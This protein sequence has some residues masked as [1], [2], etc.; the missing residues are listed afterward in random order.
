MAQIP[1]A[2]PVL[3][4]HPVDD[5]T[6]SVEQSRAYAARAAETGGDVT[7]V[8]PESGG[9]RAP[10][11]PVTSAWLYAV[12]WLTARDSQ[13]SSGTNLPFMPP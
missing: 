1:L 12:D 13:A 5:R 11:Y 8:E 9:H 7:L 6:V 4:V 2:V 3:L 10:I